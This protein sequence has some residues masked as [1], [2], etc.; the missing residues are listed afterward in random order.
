MAPRPTKHAAAK[1]S[2]GGFGRRALVIVES[3]TKAK[4]IRGFLPA[5]F[6]VAASMGHVRDLPRKA[7][8]IPPKYKD[9]KWAKFG[10]NVD[11]GFEPLYIVTPD[12]KGTIREL[13]EL[14]KDADV[15]YLATDEDREGESISWHLLEVLQPK[16]PVHRM[17][18]HEIT[19]EAIVAALEHPRDLDT[20]L[21][22]AQETRRILDRLVGY[23]V[24][25]IL[26]NKVGGNGL[27]AGRV[28]SVALR[29][30]V[31]RE[32]ERL[33]FK[34]GSYWDLTATLEH[35]KA[36]FEA[37]LV[38]LGGKRL[39]TGK[40]FDE[41]TGRIADGKDVL[42][43]NE[44][45][46]SELVERLKDAPWKVTSVEETPRTLRPYAPF[47]TSTLQQEANRKLRFGAR[48]TMQVAQKLYENGYITYMRTDSTALSEQA[49]QAARA[50][51][52]RLYGDEYLP[53]APRVYANK[54][55]NAQEAHEA[56]RPAGSSFRTPEETRL[57]GEELAL[58]SLIWKRTVAS[59][60]KDAKKTSTT[61]EIEVGDARFKASGI[62][63]D[64]PGFLRA[65]VE[66]SDDPDAALEDRDN[67]LPPLT[68]GDAPKCTDLE[69]V[70]HETKPPARYTEASLVKALEE[71]GIGRPSTYA[72]ILGTIQERGYVVA[73]GQALVP[74]FTGFAVSDFLVRHFSELVDLAFTR[75][76]EGRLDDIAGGDESWREYLGQFYSGPTGLAAQVESK[77]KLPSNE[78][79]TIALDGVE[80]TVRIGRFGA[81][82]E[83]ELDGQMVKANLPADATPADLD[84]ER[85]EQLLRQ[86]AEGP[87]SLGTHPEHGESIYLLDG[88]YGP[89]VQLGQQIEGS[90][91]KPKR[92]SLP[93][94]VTPPQVTLEMAVGLLALP[95]LL[96]NHPVS[97]RPVK[98]GLGRFGPYILHDLGKGEAEFRS[99]KA[100][101]DV[102]TVQLD[103]AVAL[104]AEPKL[105]R[106]GRAAATPIREI[107]AHPTDGKPV[108]LFEGKYGP[109]VKHGD[110]NASVP[111]GVDPMT[112]AL[113]AAVELIAEKGKAP[114][115]LLKARKAGGA[116]KA[117]PRKKAAKKSAK[118]AAP[119][120][121]AKKS[122]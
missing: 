113:D 48:R 115:G 36:A 103:R 98:A 44:A 121:T 77:A 97:G 119:K 23:T 12:K 56:I 64:F 116:K 76:M 20:N 70:G 60:M 22:H 47:T 68:V 57:G 49:I 78:G 86:R 46:A 106:G 104:L 55:A 38:T 79:R 84:P 93:K 37:G 114:K 40:D 65:Y 66:G 9:Q 83:R 91:E 26:W 24:S 122:A 30:I 3:P 75:K 63:T 17:V 32:R 11:E 107:G 101:D 105:G 6:T 94:G 96:G 85:I 109:Y 62:R 43:L 15:L 61:A 73:Q 33:A 112:F 5:G 59:Q 108:Q 111:K 1:S 110:L 13:K 29:L 74:T 51:V 21:V 4:T 50:N 82:I 69:P 39:A 54:V 100:G 41:Q 25:P 42:L 31:D 19:K 16:V 72:S 81:Y 10:V 118:K 90:K 87:A 35:G 120:K 95:R 80:G 18:F 52:T 7:A 67:P 45:Q 14:L 2:S 92:A 53:P 99:L 71:N 34:T 102:L 28:Q 88:Q 117:A 89:Y 58:Y 8:E 27:S